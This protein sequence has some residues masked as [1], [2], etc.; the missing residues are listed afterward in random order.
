M[1]TIDWVWNA[2]RVILPPRKFWKNSPRFL[3]V[4]AFQCKWSHVKIPPIDWVFNK[5]VKCARVLCNFQFFRSV[6]HQDG[7][8]SIL[9]NT[10]HAFINKLPNKNTHSNQL[11]KMKNQSCKS[12]TQHEKSTSMVHIQVTKQQIIIFHT[13]HQPLYINQVSWRSSLTLRLDLK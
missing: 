7:D 12:I 10:L 13:N 2:F 8:L 5:T 4:L 6:F 1:C 9:S 11:P 3:N